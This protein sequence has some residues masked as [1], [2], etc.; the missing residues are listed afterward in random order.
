MAGRPAATL[1]SKGV[2]QGCIGRHEETRDVAIHGVPF[3]QGHSYFHS[4]LPA[5]LERRRR[6]AGLSFAAS[7]KT[8][9]TPERRRAKTVPGQV[10][11]IDG[12]DVTTVAHTRGT[13][14]SHLRTALEHRGPLLRG[15]GLHR[16]PRA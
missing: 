6:P 11:E 10:C 12:V 7:S 16:G 3:L 13:I 9:R 2:V 4:L 5:P 8:M 14:G 1:A 15:A